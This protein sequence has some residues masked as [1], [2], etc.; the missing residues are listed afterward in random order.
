M[1]FFDA[2]LKNEVCKSGIVSFELAKDLNMSKSILNSWDLNARTHAGLSLGFDFLFLLVYASFIALLIYNVNH[3]LWKNKKFYKFG[4]AF[5]LLI[6]IAAFSDIIENIALIALLRGDLIQT[7]SSMA[8]Y[9][10]MVKFL[11]IA[12]CILYLLWSW[13][14]LLFKPKKA[15]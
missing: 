8:Y 3:A 5:M 13:M 4:K 1:R 7:W 15:I 10:A 12:I 2:S 6:F 14:I 11:L 9:S